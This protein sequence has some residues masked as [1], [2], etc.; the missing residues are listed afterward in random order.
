MTT[1]RK[2]DTVRAL[3]F[4]QES[5][6]AEATA[7]AAGARFEAS[8]PSPLEGDFR[9]VEE[10]M[11]ER[12]TSPELGEAGPPGKTTLVTP[13]PSARRPPTPLRAIPTLKA[14]EPKAPPRIEFHR[15]VQVGSEL[16]YIAQA[17]RAG[18]LSGDGS[19]TA[20]CHARLAADLTPSA[21]R[22]PPQVLLTTSCTTSLEMAA[23][24]VRGDR[25]EA[26]EVILPS[27][28]FVST[29][30]A[31]VLHG[32]TPVFVDICEHDGNIDPERIAE[33]VTPR[34][35]AIVPV[36][37]GGVPCDMD[38][39]LSIAK[40]HGIAVVEDAAQAL[41]SRWR[42]RPAGTMGELGCFSFHD[43]KNIACGEGGALVI[44]AREHAERAAHLREKGTNRTRY[45]SGQ[46]DKYTWVDLG[47]SYLPSELQAAY[48]LAQLEQADRIQ[49]R[50]AA[51]CMRYRE[52]LADLERAGCFRLAH[53]L[54][55]AHGNHHI[56]WLLLSG[57][58]ERALLTAHL[59]QRGIDARSHYVALHLSPMGK[60]WG[61]GPGS[62][63]V[64]ERFAEGLLRLPLHPHVTGSDADRVIDAIR[65]FYGRTGRVSQSRSV[66]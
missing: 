37:Y 41:G 40:S 32:F 60:R 20:R 6:P 16:G 28:T 51:V 34:T 5:E 17:M 63:P 48:L 35:R 24:L 52:G 29:A 22:K 30:N 31:F 23:L 15:H 12:A 66:A 49:A 47:G 36:H 55:H 3:P 53:P 43:T 54:P 58:E 38:A 50:R 65:E 45:L 8:N 21:T 9:P 59:A 33:A 10:E 26:G 44:N 14:R 4:E 62:L 61:R 13:T 46:V 57:Y 27:F 11:E 7:N 2:T 56:F 64:T 1:A 19:F 39:I 18:G 42:D 25:E